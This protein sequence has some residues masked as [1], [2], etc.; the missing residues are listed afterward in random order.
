MEKFS[1][2]YNTLMD[3][4]YEKYLEH[5]KILQLETK[6]EQKEKQKQKSKMDK[7]T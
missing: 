7:H 1:L 2:G 6:E 5:A 3:F 4:P